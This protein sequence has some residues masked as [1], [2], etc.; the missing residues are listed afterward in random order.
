MH[1]E[2]TDVIGEHFGVSKAEWKF[3]LQSKLIKTTWAC[4]TQAFDRPCGCVFFV[5]SVRVLSLPPVPEEMCG[6]EGLVECCLCGHSQSKLFTG[7]QFIDWN[8]HRLAN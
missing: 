8:I 3:Y 4:Q 6:S 5:A 7:K 1:S 2:S